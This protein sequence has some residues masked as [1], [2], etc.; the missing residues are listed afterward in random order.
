[1]E[2]SV[3]GSFDTFV[4]SRAGD[5]FEI[6]VS[7]AGRLIEAR[8]APIYD[9]KLHWRARRANDSTVFEFVHPPT[10]ILYCQA[11]VD[12]DFTRV[13]VL[14]SES[15]RNL[16]APSDGRT[17]DWELPYP[18]EQLLLVPAF[19]LRDTVLFHACGA[20]VSNRGF[21]FAGHSGDGK[22]TLAGLL[23]DEGAPLLS[24]ERI[25]IRRTERGFFA[26]GTPWPGDGNVVSNGS[27]PLAGMFVLRKAALHALGPSSP[28]LAPELIARA[29]VPYYLPQT[30]SRILEPFRSRIR[31]PLPGAPLHSRAGTHLSLARSR[32]ILFRQSLTISSSNS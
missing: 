16:L 6:R 13:E 10:G 8:G 3:S 27:Q 30:A 22:S 32:R 20:I 23:E 18:L 19:A 2:G 25:A 28:T 14:F 9:S 29:I 31:R 24:D 5:D 4:D 11:R 12:E 7:S 15:A 1:M 17:R 21:V 26:F